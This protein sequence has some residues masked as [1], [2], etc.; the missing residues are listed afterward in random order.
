MLSFRVFAKLHPRRFVSPP[1]RHL[2]GRRLLRPCRD[3]RLSTSS[4]PPPT[5]TTR[6][7]PLP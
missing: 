2:R 5:F 1:P 3:C 7:P 6:C 4:A